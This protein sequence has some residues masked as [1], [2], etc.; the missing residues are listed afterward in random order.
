MSLPKKRDNRTFH[1]INP[2]STATFSL[3]DT[4]LTVDLVAKDSSKAYSKTFTPQTYKEHSLTSYFDSPC[5][6]FNFVSQVSDKFV[7]TDGQG[8]I[9]IAFLAEELQERTIQISLD[10]HS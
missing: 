5:S 7:S 10:G 1:L 6:L 4:V 9:K 8:N 2:H 3:D